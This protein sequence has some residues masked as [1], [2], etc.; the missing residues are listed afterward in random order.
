[1]PSSIPNR[2][3]RTFALLCPLLL[4]ASIPSQTTPP[5][6]TASPVTP[7]SDYAKAQEAFA[8][9][10]WQLAAQLFARATAAENL[11]TTTPHTDALFFQAKSLINLA[12]YPEAETAL[13][14][15]L[16]QQPHHAPALY[17][18]GLVQQR[19]NHP[20]ASLH[21]FTE[22]ASLAPPT[23]ENL[24]TIALSYV[25]LQ[26]YPDAIRWLSRALQSDPQNAEAWYDLARAHMH[27]G[28]FLKAVTELQRSLA[29][30]PH[31]PKAL[32]NLGICLEA[33]NRPEDA[34]KAYE[35]AVAAAE[36]T[37]HPGEQP[38]VDFGTLLNT[39]NDFSRAAGL[40]TRA[41]A[42]APQNSRAFAELA[43]ACLGLGQIAPAQTAMEKAVAL[44]PK[45]SRLHFQLGRIYRSAGLPAKAQS[46]FQRSASLYG[47]HSAE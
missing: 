18:L 38:F 13:Q 14:Q 42:I 28:D 19:R 23:S 47:Q 33:Q 8:A 16:Q 30:S 40:L 1:M 3:L 44:D 31:N 46:E 6:Q 32:D 15:Y 39:R 24:R 7:T 10:H 29:L 27:E 35:E 41:T 34:V 22:A 12:Q 5:I 43:R 4:P 26:S 20:E 21:T 25:L 37:T 2:P 45:N 36:A 9:Q 11:Q 17:L